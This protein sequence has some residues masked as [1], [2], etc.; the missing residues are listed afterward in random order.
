MTDKLA[1]ADSVQ[2][3]KGVVG[4]WDDDCE[5][6]IMIIDVW[7]NFECSIKEHARSRLQLLKLSV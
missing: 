6:L 1:G 7:Y 5:Q 4:M 2:R 3:W